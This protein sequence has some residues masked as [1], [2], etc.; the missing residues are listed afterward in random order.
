MKLREIL[1][2][3]VTD[4]KL[5]YPMCWMFHR[6]KYFE[7]IDGEWVAKIH[8]SGAPIFYLLDYENNW[9]IEMG[10]NGSIELS[11]DPNLPNLAFELI[12]NYEQYERDFDNTLKAWI[13]DPNRPKGA[14]HGL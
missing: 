6:D 12:T 14:N 5:K 13:N 4:G 10:I 2:S 3:L 1:E 9:E 7:Q 11:D 8:E